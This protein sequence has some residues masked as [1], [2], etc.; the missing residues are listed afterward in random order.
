MELTERQLGQERIVFVS[1][2]GRSPVRA[3]L[4]SARTIHAGTITYDSLIS[5]MN[6][7]RQQWQ[8]AEAASQQRSTHHTHPDDA[9]RRSASDGTAAAGWVSCSGDTGPSPPPASTITPRVGGVWLC[10]G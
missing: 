6:K 4:L 9:P 2:G 3:A 7:G 5:A 1:L 8:K 10:A